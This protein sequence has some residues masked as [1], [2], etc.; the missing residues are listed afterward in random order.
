MSC[1]SVP[2]SIERTS[3]TGTCLQGSSWV[4]QFNNV[5]CNQLHI[6]PP[7]LIQRPKQ[8]SL[9]IGVLAW[10]DFVIVVVASGSVAEAKFGI[11][12]SGRIKLSRFVVLS[13]YRNVEALEDFVWANLTKAMRCHRGFCG[14]IKVMLNTPASHQT[15]RTPSS[16]L[17]QKL[18][19]KLIC[20]SCGSFGTLTFL[21]PQKLPEDLC[22]A[23]IGFLPRV[24]LR[25]L[26]SSRLITQP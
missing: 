18:L 24:T 3:S 12:C 26:N 11:L 4:S 7:L 14:Y 20:Q 5:I 22:I 2:V 10:N 25:I 8:A 17:L 6:Y 23:E 13:N 1:L 15:S 21:A 9:D 16:N 19:L